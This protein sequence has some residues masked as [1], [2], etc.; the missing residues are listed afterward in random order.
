MADDYFCAPPEDDDYFHAPKDSAEYNELFAAAWID[1]IARLEAALLPSINI[2]ALHPNRYWGHTALHMA[3][4]SGDIPAIRLLIA[5]GAKVD[6][7]SDELRTP[8]HDAVYHA[9][10]DSIKILLEKGADITLEAGEEE[11]TMLNLALLKFSPLITSARFKTVEFLLDRGC[12][13]NRDD[14]CGRGSTMMQLAAGLGDIGLTQLFL[15]RG[16][17]INFSPNS[18]SA[19]VNAAGGGNAKVVQLLLSHAT[20]ADLA[21]SRE[22]MHWA[23]ASGRIEVVKLLIDHGFNINEIVEDCYVGKTPLL[24]TCP[25]TR[26]SKTLVMASFLIEKGARISARDRE[27]NDDDEEKN[28]DQPQKRDEIEQRGESFISWD[29]RSD[30]PG[31]LENNTFEGAIGNWIIQGTRDDEVNA[32]G[33]PD[34]IGHVFHLTKYGNAIVANGILRAM[35][36]EQAKMMNQPADP[37][38]IDP[39][40][41]PISGADID[42][43]PPPAPAPAPYVV[44]GGNGVQAGK[45]HVHISE[46]ENCES[47]KSDLST[48]VTIWDVGGNQIGF[49]SVKK[50]GATDPL[51]VKSKLEDILIVA[52]EHRGD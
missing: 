1:D 2:N 17:Q 24:A 21:S 36:A 5:R 42:K 46:Y 50:A 7:R 52:S 15:D 14:G 19:I 33:L 34:W 31:S 39:G 35:I 11:Y 4:I 32:Q 9:K 8:L 20:D 45:C 12:D 51:A 38:I 27:D 29:T 30:T 43:L 44:T 10:L 26:D 3:A 49:Q 13:P 48:E 6:Q 22:A 28:I 41:C 47:D 16:A 23:A 25:K 18:P 37:V 40:Q